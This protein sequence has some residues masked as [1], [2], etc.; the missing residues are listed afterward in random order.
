MTLHSLSAEEACSAD[1]VFSLLIGESPSMRHIKEAILK[2]ACTDATVLMQGESGT[3]KELVAKAIHIHSARKNNAF[4]AIN[5]GAIPE[6]LMESMLFGYE[7][8]AFSGAS[9]SGQKGLLEQADGGTFFLDEVAEMPASLQVKLLRTLQEHKIRR[10]GGKNVRLL[11]VRIIA[12]SNRNLREEVR[13]GRFRADL[14]FRLD[15]IPVLIPPLRERKG[16]VRLLVSHFLRQFGEAKGC[17]FR[18]TADLM[19]RFEKY[20]WPGN[21]RELK[22]FVE[23]GVCFCDAGLLTLELLAPRFHLALPEGADESDCGP[24]MPALYKERAEPV[25]A[26]MQA[27]MRMLLAQFGHST[28][29]KRAL[30][31]HMGISLATLYRR[32]RR[33]WPAARKF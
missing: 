24:T 33:L 1:S 16:D 22:N 17:K 4:V 26:Q 23:Y 25:S 21:I 2:M 27:Q 13:R 7:A 20:A 15:V 32:L 6:A 12:A 10:L 28:D 9:N 18:V 29:G 11:N 3:G 31:Q 30:A 8:G 5:C 14:F 19:R